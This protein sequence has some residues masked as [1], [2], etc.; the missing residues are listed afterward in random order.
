MGRHRPSQQCHAENS[1]IVELGKCLARAGVLPQKTEQQP[2]GT[3]PVSANDSKPAE[4]SIAL[5]Q[6]TDAKSACTW[7]FRAIPALKEPNTFL[8]KKDFER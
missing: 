2:D 6:A 1:H 3:G 5:A 8:C 7:S 4:C